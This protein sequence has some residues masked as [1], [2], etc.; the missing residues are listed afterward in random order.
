MG[1][2]RV[3]FALTRALR[4]AGVDVGEPLGRD[5]DVGDAEVVLLCVPDGAVAAAAARLPRDL[6]V[7][8]CS[9]AMA[10]DVLSPH[11]G[12]SLHPLMT[13]T[14]LAPAPL[15]GCV[16][17]VDGTSARSL[18]IA[19]DLA[20]RLDMRPIAVP[21]RDRATYHA[22][23]SVAANFT[24]T[25]L[26][27]AEDLAKTAGLDRDAYLPLVEAAVRNWARTGAAD[28]LTGPVARGDEITVQRQRDAVQARCPGAAE[29][30]DA[31]VSATKTLAANKR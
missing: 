17:A 20:T 1:R 25:V 12:F 2:G 16:A 11:E 21:E 28:S 29:L 31:L 8:H 19:R 22:A 26:G 5:P 7:G 27:L 14:H 24:V 4:Q 30:F 9:G 10:L 3:G 15:A 18:A 13:I 23:A 6:V